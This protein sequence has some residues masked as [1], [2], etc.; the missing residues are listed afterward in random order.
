MKSMR[1]RAG[2]VGIGMAAGFAA[3]LLVLSPRRGESQVGYPSQAQA[4]AQQNISRDLA[5]INQKLDQLLQGNRR[6]M[7]MLTRTWENTRRSR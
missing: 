7:D 3:S 5:S 2:L 1:A 4:Y 6:I